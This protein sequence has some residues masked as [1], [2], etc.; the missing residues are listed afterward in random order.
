MIEREAGAA[1]RKMIADRSPQTISFA[2]A[3]GERRRSPW[4]PSAAVRHRMI[5]RRRSLRA[6]V[7][8]RNSFALSTIQPAYT[9]RDSIHSEA[10]SVVSGNSLLP[11][12]DEL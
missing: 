9:C 4:P 5:A 8:S 11:S 6:G 12:P 3:R 2:S 10:L 1:W 7:D